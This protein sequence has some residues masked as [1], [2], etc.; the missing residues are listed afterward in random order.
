MQIKVGLGKLTVLPSVAAFMQ[1]QRRVNRV[2]T[3]PILEPHI[4]MLATLPLYHRDPFDRIFIA[5][6]LAEG[7]TIATADPVFRQ[8]LVP[9]LG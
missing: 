3:L 9:L 8:Y 2:E 7:W 1:V 6:A 4:W 5:Q